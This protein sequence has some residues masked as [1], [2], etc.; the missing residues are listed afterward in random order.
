LEGVAWFPSKDNRLSIFSEPKLRHPREG[1]IKRVRALAWDLFIF[2]WCETLTT[3][4]K[5]NTFGVPVVTS[6]DQGLLEAIQLCPLRAVLI[7]DDERLVEAIFDDDLE[8]Q[9]ALNDLLPQSTKERLRNRL[10]NCRNTDVSRH[11]LSSFILQLE[12]EVGTL[13]AARERDSSNRSR[14]NAEDDGLSRD[15]C[16]RR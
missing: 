4:Y 3:E 12:K 6:F 10:V 5:G 13:V 7:H 1:T 2:R 15:R 11:A 8:F 9:Q 16:K 14:R